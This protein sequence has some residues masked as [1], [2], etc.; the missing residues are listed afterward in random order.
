MCAFLLLVPLFSGLVAN[1]RV[2]DQRIPVTVLTGFLGSGKTTLLNHLLTKQHG[3]RLAVGIDDALLGK[4]AREE[5]EPEIIEMMN[6]CICCTVRQDLI[7]VLKRISERVS[8]GK[9]NIDA[10]VIETT[11]C[12]S[13]SRHVLC[14]HYDPS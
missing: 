13:C 12:L 2:K 11:V 10:V 6:G 3:K 9:L 5:A 7:V 1:A 14:E 8:S 4:N